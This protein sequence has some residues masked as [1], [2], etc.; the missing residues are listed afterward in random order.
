M[1]LYKY[2]NFRGIFG[3]LKWLYHNNVPNYNFDM[4]NH[5]ILFQEDKINSHYDSV[6]NKNDKMRD[7]LDIYDRHHF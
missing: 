4:Y 2:G 7:T 6:R 3:K 1:V 5:V